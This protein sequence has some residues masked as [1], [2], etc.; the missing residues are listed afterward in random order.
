[1]RDHNVLRSFQFAFRGVWY[2]L[3]TE[4]NS[5]IHLGIAGAVV[6][7]GVWLRLPSDRWAVLVLTIGFVLVSELVNTALEAV[8]D[9]I[10]PKYH[11]LAKVAKDVMAGAV[12]LAAMTSI[13]V[14]L[15]VLGP[16]LW[17]KLAL[18]LS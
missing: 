5:H 10:S 11:P 14:G 7:L 18:S 13:I 12:L 8:V 15:L 17:S 6:L 1:M 3:R 9:L 4:Q 2:V 16:P